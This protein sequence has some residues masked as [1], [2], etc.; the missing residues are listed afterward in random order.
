[1]IEQ[2]ENPTLA[3]SPTTV[4]AMGLGPTEITKLKTEI[5]RCSGVSILANDRKLVSIVLENNGCQRSIDWTQNAVAKNRMARWV[6]P[7]HNLVIDVFE[8][9]DGK[10]RISMHHL[11]EWQ[12][13][14]DHLMP[15]FAK[16]IAYAISAAGASVRYKQDALAKYEKGG[17]SD[18]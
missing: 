15:R 13:P 18:E 3:G 11:R 16:S 12:S 7:M 10:I 2:K 1:M 4:Q 5:S 9:S 14:Q 17:L 8:N 6:H